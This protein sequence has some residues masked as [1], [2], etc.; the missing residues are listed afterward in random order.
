M[1]KMGNLAVGY[2]VSGGSVFPS[3]RIAGRL[4]SVSGARVVR[5]LGLV[6]SELEAFE[7]HNARYL[8]K[9]LSLARVRWSM[10]PVMGALAAAG[11][12]IYLLWTRRRSRNA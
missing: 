7:E 11:V 9:S 4:A 5:S 10:G 1:D 12:L 2:T 3:I 6:P 8:E